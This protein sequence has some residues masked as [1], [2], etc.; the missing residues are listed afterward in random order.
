MRDFCGGY[1]AVKQNDLWMFLD[2][3]GDILSSNNAPLVFD[4]VTDFTNGYA[5]VRNGTTLSIIDAD[6]HYVISG[7]TFNDLKVAEYFDTSWW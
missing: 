1:A 4:K 2:R 3:K 5:L 7:N 6:G